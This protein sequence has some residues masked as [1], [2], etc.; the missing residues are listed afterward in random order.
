MK[1]T[2]AVVALFAACAMALPTEVE[3]RAAVNAG[4]LDLIG[5]LEGFRANFYTDTVGH[6]AIGKFTPI[7]TLPWY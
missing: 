7:R 4:G 2:T 1:F 3:K 5:E 6:K